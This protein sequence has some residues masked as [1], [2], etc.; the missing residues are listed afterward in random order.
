M[1]KLMKKQCGCASQRGFS[2]VEMLVVMAMLSVVMLAVT[3]LFIPAVRSTSVQT[4]VSDIQANLRLAMNRMTN[5]LVLAGFLVMPGDTTGGGAAGAIFW[6]PVGS[7]NPSADL[8]IRTRTVG[9]A[10]GRVIAYNSAK[11]VLSDADMALAFPSG[12]SIRL[13]VPTTSDEVDGVVYSVTDNTTTETIDTVTYPVL[14][15]TPSPP[16]VPNETVVLRVRDSASPSMQTIRYRVNNGALE[17]IVNGATQLLARNV[18]SVFFEYTPPSGAVK[19]VDI[20]LSG[21]STGLSGGGAE[22]SAKDRQLR[23]SVALRNV[24]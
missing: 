5:D 22:S 24:Y 11:I 10:F 20:T 7:S 23:T 14:T 19:R 8:T 6:E 13:F 3:S 9:N 12:T 16:T 18:D 21:Q 15:V 1:L 17:R 2:L 4:E